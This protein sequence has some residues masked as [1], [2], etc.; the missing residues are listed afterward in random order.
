MSST[1]SSPT[2]MRTRSG[3]TPDVDLLLVGQLLVGRAG[4]VDDQRL[5][6]ADVG[7]V[8]D[9]PQLLDEAGARSPARP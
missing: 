5:G 2:E 6:V 3:L 1:S 9:Q 8:R 7:Q 4:G